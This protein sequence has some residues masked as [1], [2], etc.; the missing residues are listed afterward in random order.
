MMQSVRFVAQCFLFDKDDFE[1]FSK[2]HPSAW[3]EAPVGAWVTNTFGV[4]K[5]VKDYRAHKDEQFR[6]PLK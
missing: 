4:D 6:K 5:L 1:E 2:T 3:Y